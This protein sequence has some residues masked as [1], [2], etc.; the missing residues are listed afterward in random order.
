MKKQT[1]IAG[2]QYKGLDN[3]YELG[4]I[5]KKEKTTVKTYNRSNL[6]YNSEYRFYEYCNLKNFNSLSRKS[7]HLISDL[8]YNQ[9]N[10]FSRQSET[11]ERMCN[12]V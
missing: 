9:L 1:S 3:T 8:F 11:M 2:K 6:I 10:K 7:K 4:K 12:C 5:I